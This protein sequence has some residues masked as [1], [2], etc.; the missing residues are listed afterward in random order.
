VDQHDA[1]IEV[2]DRQD[3]GTCFRVTLPLEHESVRP[4]AISRTD[5]RRDPRPA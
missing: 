4:T 1:R 2:I 5:G 3:A